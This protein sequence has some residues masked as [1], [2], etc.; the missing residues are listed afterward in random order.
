M[1]GIGVEVK[2]DLSMDL[3]PFFFENMACYTSLSFS[4]PLFKALLSRSMS[5]LSDDFVYVLI[6]F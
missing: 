5:N 2:N 1:V 3:C 4:R 6:D